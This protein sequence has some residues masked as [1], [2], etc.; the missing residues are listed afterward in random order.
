MNAIANLEVDVLGRALRVNA[1]VS[2]ELGG[3][4]GKNALPAGIVHG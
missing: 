3:D 1:F 2:M 4:G